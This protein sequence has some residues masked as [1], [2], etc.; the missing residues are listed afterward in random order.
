M[1]EAI[2]YSLDEKIQGELIQWMK[3]WKDDEEEFPLDGFP[4]DESGRPILTEVPTGR[5]EPTLADLF[6]LM[7]D[8][9]SSAFEDLIFGE[10]DEKNPNLSFEEVMELVAPIQDRWEAKPLTEIWQ[11]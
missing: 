8:E 9:D 4:L 10:I 3:N 5:P 1:S 11:Y 7:D 2:D 6:S